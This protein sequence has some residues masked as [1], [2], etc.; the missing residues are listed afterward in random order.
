MVS[1]LT[2][3]RL[4]HPSAY[5]FETAALL[6]AS[7]FL[8]AASAQTPAAP[9]GNPTAKWLVEQHPRWQAAFDREVN[10]A[11]DKDVADLNK[12][13]L[14]TVEKSFNQAARD[15]QLDAALVY[16]SERDRIAGAGAGLLEEVT[17][18]PLAVETLRAT[19]RQ[20][21]AALE[22]ARMD[23]AKK[24]LAR[25]DAVLGQNLVALTKAQRLEEA[26]LLKAKREEIAAAWTKEMPGSISGGEPVTAAPLAA[27]A[28]DADSP[29]VWKSRDGS[30]RALVAKLLTLGAVVRAPEPIKSADDLP[31]ED[32][33]ITS[34]DFSK[35]VTDQALAAVIGLKVA[36]VSLR[37]ESAAKLSLKDWEQLAN[38]KTLLKVDLVGSPKPGV[39]SKLAQVQTL[40]EINMSLENG[41][42]HKESDIASLGALPNLQYLRVAQ[43]PMTGVA[44]ASWPA[45][46]PLKNLLVPQSADFDESSLHALLIT[47]PE[48]TELSVGTFSVNDAKL[49]V[50]E[51]FASLK[52]FRVSRGTPPANLKKLQMALPNVKVESRT[53]ERF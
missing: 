18:L 42:A 35:N 27:P 45:K 5:V 41:H 30:P 37:G 39:F 29:P 44:F 50:L 1:S 13:Y 47:A 19:Y 16:R 43:A 3:Q 40:T 28:V 49:K 32:F 38:S 8:F 25:Y 36:G 6:F 21:L 52:K 31:G 17:D 15:G 2:S 4:R 9:A 46:R 7:A 12:K 23:R 11:F 53:D 34:V 26:L 14:A 24:I 22:A 10:E 20:S 33:L 51:Q 48:L